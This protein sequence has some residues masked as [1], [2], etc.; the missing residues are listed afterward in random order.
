M[1]QGAYEHGWRRKRPQLTE[2][3]I[4]ELIAL[5]SA[6]ERVTTVTVVEPAS[7]LA[8]IRTTLGKVIGLPAAILR[9]LS[10]RT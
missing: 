9:N 2:R 3:E 1:E 4:K 10:I 5:I 8:I 7:D 6:D